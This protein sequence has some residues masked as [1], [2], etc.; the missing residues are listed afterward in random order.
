MYAYPVTCHSL[1][2]AVCY[3]VFKC[4]ALQRGVAW[5]SVLQCECEFVHC[6]LAPNRSL[7]VCCSMLQCVA[8]CCSVLQCDAV[9]CSEL[10]CGCEFVCCSLTPN[11]SLTVCCRV[12][13]CVAVWFSV[14][15]C[16]A[17]CCSVLQSVAVCCS[18]LQCG[19]ESI[20]VWMRVRA[21]LSGAQH[22]TYCVLQ[23]VA[24][25]CS[26]L[27]CLQSVAVC[28]SV[29]QCMGFRHPICVWLYL[30]MGREKN[31]SLCLS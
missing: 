25:F 21:L 14:L 15:Q 20:A 29:L 16:V 19:C 24:V 9:C 1:C 4:S 30:C 18:V 3:S 27:K 26:L 8:V 5:C 13:H 6:S 12:L 11:R 22:V 28:C 7:T 10:Q 23:G 31:Y 2:V 17:V